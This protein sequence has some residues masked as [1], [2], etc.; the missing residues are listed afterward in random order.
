MDYTGRGGR[1]E[2]L[3]T[4]VRACA[5]D[6][7]FVAVARCGGGTACQCATGHYLCHSPRLSDVSPRRGLVTSKARVAGF[8]RFVPK[9]VHWRQQMFSVPRCYGP[10]ASIVG[11]MAQLVRH[12]LQGSR[13]YL[14]GG[15]SASVA[16]LWALRKEPWS[17]EPQQSA[18]DA[19]ML[20]ST[21]LSVDLITCTALPITGSTPGFARPQAAIGTSSA[22]PPVL[23]TT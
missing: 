1:H 3:R 19:C 23:G 15:R 16:T 18:I 22:S 11:S 7:G 2:S 14:S 21:T 12:V 20:G 17:S 6:P 9:F 13:K 10:S 8:R 5:D 4:P